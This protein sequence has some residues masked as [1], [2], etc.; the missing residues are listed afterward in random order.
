MICLALNSRVGLKTQVGQCVRNI[1]IGLATG[2][3]I[4]VTK[5]INKISLN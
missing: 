3:A 4:V 1:V 5:Y 2:R